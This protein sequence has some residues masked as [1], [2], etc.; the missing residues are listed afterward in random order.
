MTVS[1]LAAGRGRLAAGRGGLAAGRNRP[2][3]L[4]GG[5]TAVV[6]IVVA[7]INDP[8]LQGEILFCR[9]QPGRSDR[10]RV[11]RIFP[12]RVCYLYR[13]VTGELIE[14]QTGR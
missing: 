14:L 2:A 4:R 1:R 10:E 13:A 7:V 11:Q 12:N 8:D 6:I 5:A 3:A 9:F